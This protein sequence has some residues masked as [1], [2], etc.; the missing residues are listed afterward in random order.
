MLV[1][2]RGSMMLTCLDERSGE[3]INL[4]TLSAEDL[5]RIHSAK[6]RQ[7][8]GIDSVCK[9]CH[10]PVHLV[11]HPCGSWYWRHNRGRPHDC[12][13][14]EFNH[15]ESAE[16]HRGKLLIAQGLNGLQGWS[17]EP[18][19]HGSKGGTDVF[20]DV[21]AE[22]TE[23]AVHAL[24]VDTAFEVQLSP[25]STGDFVARTASIREV[26]GA[27]AVWATPHAASLDSVCGLIVDGSAAMVVDRAYTHVDQEAALDPL[28]LDRAVRGI[29]GG[30]RRYEFAQS[31]DIISTDPRARPPWI[32]W[33][34]GQGAPRTVARRVR[35]TDVPID[36]D[37]DRPE[38]LTSVT[39]IRRPATDSRSEYLTEGWTDAHWEG[40]S[41]M[42]LARRYAGVALDGVDF[43]ALRRFPEALSSL[44]AR[45]PSLCRGRVEKGGALDN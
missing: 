25:Q 23:D 39:E 5:D 26:T 17:V 6:K 19:R 44:R 1:P 31:G 34:R 33:T 20:V 24:Q 15:S 12:S 29:W 30:R 4:S 42:A 35:P 36:R 28:A 8:V 14:V 40:R 11:H 3:I 18:E 13:Q 2:K 22:R 37:C 32:V 9:G 27:Q 7:D 16:H 41:R 21:F 43:E 38:A 45:T 10:H